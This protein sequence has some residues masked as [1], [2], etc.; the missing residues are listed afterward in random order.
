MTRSGWCHVR[1]EGEPANRV[2]LDVD[3]A[4]AFTN[5]V[6]FEVEGSALRNPGSA[7]YALDWIDKLENLADAWP[8]WRSVRER[9]HVF[10]QFEQAREVYR[11]G[12]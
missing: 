11:A 6:W 2:P 1:T 8:G 12:L 3:Y 5:P 7:Q 4:Q 9:A 10:G